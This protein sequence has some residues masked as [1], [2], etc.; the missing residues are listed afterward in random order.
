MTFT[1]LS[2]QQDAKV[3]TSNQWI[4]DTYQVMLNNQNIQLDIMESE[5][6]LHG[7]LISGNTELIENIDEKI[8]DTFSRFALAKT[9]TSDN[10]EQQILLE[11]LEPF[12][13]YKIDT[14]KKIIALKQKNDFKNEDA[15]SLINQAQ[16]TSLKIKNILDEIYENEERLSLTRA[17]DFESN[18]NIFNIISNS[19]V[20]LNIV[21]L[22][23]IMLFF[24]RILSSLA[25]SQTLAKQ[26]ESLL[27]AIIG[28]SKESI[29]ALDLNYNFLAFNDTFKKTFYT[30]FG[31]QISIGTNIKKALAHV[32][33]EQRKAMAIWD[34]ALKGEEF[35][36][37]EKFGPNE[38]DQIPYEI[39]YSSIYNEDNQLI[40]AS[41]IAR[42][43]EKRLSEGATL[44]EAKEK[45]EISLQQEKNKAHEMS[46]I[47][48]MNNKLR[49]S[50]SLEETLS[51]ASLYIKKL[52]PFCSGIIY[53]MNHSRNYLESASEW[54]EPEVME[55]VISPDQCW[56]LR[57]GKIYF[58]LNENENIA[59]KHRAGIDPH[60]ASICVP[61]LALNEI[62]GIL[63]L[64]ITQ[65]RNMQQ[66]EIINLYEKNSLMIQSVAGQISLSIS[67]I[68][69]Q[70]VL[71]TSSTRDLLTNLYNRSYLN[72]TFE[73]DLQRAKRK[74][75]PMAIVMMDLDFFKDVNDTYGHEAGDIVLREIGKLLIAQTR[76]SDIVCRYGGE[77]IIIILYDTPLDEAIEKIEH[78]RTDI[79][80]LEF[81]FVNLLT[82][83]ASFGIAMFPEQGETPEQLIKAADE[84]L[85]LSK[86]AGR[87]RVTVYKPPI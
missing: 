64:Q 38:N 31:K 87:N 16:N 8:K 69:L 65:S 15:A 77:E 55:K 37:I 4:K 84:A 80:T 85:Y 13:K 60:N 58:Y 50:T 74:D 72:E 14:L 25:S 10:P 70:E 27:K 33:E 21:L 29:G 6:L 76:T 12:I 75:S 45:L 5:S 18:F 20:I 35:T 1:L 79:S 86:K 3:F 9:L 68:K 23:I 22:F 36:I 49:S 52:L 82:I 67:N 63:Y 32:P 51:M 44:K 66:S 83:T 54:N 81:R 56:G 53:L 73:R 28:G 62:L 19:A 30:L 24:N 48:D 42:N 7:Y 59:C 43:V 71:K 57:Q 78:L 11:K 39:T 26:S 40:G 46:I 17:K 34:R 2:Y 41:V 47:N 61:L